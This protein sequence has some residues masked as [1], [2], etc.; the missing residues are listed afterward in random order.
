MPLNYVVDH[1]SGNVFYGSQLGEVRFLTT[2]AVQHDSVVEEFAYIF[3]ISSKHQVVFS[4]KETQI[5]VTRI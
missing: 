4:A 3:L 1:P 5:A 2:C